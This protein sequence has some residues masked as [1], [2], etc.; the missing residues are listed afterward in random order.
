[1]RAS[2]SLI[3]LSVSIALISGT[4]RSANSQEREP[5]GYVSEGGID[6]ALEEVLSAPEF[7]YL[8]RD[9]RKSS[10][11]AQEKTE[12]NPS[13]SEAPD[14]IE[15][16]DESFWS[17]L[18][19]RFVRLLVLIAVAVALGLLAFIAIR[20]GFPRWSKKVTV[21]DASDAESKTEPTDLV[22]PPGE[23]PAEGYRERAVRLAEGG[24]CQ[25]AIRELLL[26]S[27]SWIERAGWIRHRRG[28]TNR[29]YGRAAR[30][31]PRVQGALEVIVHRFEEVFFGRREASS[32]SFRECLAAFENGFPRAEDDHAV[33]H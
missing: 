26:G 7:R 22:H 18:I 14:R 24:S 2:T 10:K 9:K 5:T 29:D 13:E 28:L 32:D 12:S 31:D 19:G 11:P 25:A 8:L 17:S 21:N 6:R 23:I 15:E 33:A 30:R 1:M 20:S 4:S 16:E 27:M 3:V